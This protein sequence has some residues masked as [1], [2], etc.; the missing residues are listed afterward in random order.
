MTTT[1]EAFVRHVC[2]KARGTNPTEIQGLWDFPGGPVVK[3]S[4][5]NARDAGS[6]P[7]WGTKTPHA[8]E[9]LNPRATTRESCATVKDPT[10]CRS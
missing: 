10:R 3:N 9:Q 5:L 7:G 2:S 6:V 4:P 8:L 1:S